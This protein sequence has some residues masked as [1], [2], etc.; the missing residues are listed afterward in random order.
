[1][2]V[3]V[4][5]NSWGVPLDPSSLLTLMALADHANDDGHSV[6]PGNKRL[7][8]K[9][10]TSIRQVQRN[11]KHLQD[12][13]L[14]RREKYASGGRGKAVEWSINVLLLESMTYTSLFEIKGDIC[15]RKGCHLSTE[16]MTS[17]SPQPSG[18]IIN[19]E[20]IS[21]S[22]ENPR[23]EGEELREYLSRLAEIAGSN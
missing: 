20:E 10:S 18:T 23:A 1:M 15:D 8:W 21:I 12:H 3:R 5:S 11:L 16:T 22:R 9:T 13:G 4:M 6:Y 7:A 19:R 17:T 14:I 2:S